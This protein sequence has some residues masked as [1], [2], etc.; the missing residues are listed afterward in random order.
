LGAQN[1][2]MPLPTSMA[3][4]PTANKAKVADRIAYLPDFFLN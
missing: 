3:G 1:P 2:T 4:T